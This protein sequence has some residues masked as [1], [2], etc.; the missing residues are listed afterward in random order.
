MRTDTRELFALPSGT[1]RWTASRKQ[2]VLIAV[3]RGALT[4]E[5]AHRRYRLT[6]EEIEE[7]RRRLERHG[8][9]G[10]KIKKLQ[11]ERRRDRAGTPLA[12]PSAAS[13][14]TVRPK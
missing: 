3:D 11:E 12:P 5:D 1:G 14:W 2:Q 9:N 10:L 8:P 7:W 4:I 13:P 6:A